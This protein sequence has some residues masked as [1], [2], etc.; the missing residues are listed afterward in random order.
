MADSRRSCVGWAEGRAK[1]SGTHWRKGKETKNQTIEKHD[2]KVKA[3]QFGAGKA[4]LAHKS[5]EL[6]AG[7]KTG[8]TRPSGVEVHLLS[9]PLTNTDS[10]IV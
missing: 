1:G 5:G 7:G 8:R 10:E 9:Q 2:R 3:A 6:N 4:L